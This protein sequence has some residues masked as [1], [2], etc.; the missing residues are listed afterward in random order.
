M[1]LTDDV[2]TGGE[3]TAGSGDWNSVT[4]TRTDAS[5]EAE[6]TLVIYTDIDAPADKKF[7]DKYDDKTLVGRHPSILTL[8]PPI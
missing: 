7:N 4:M 8:L 3:T 5:A 6:H 1:A 2:Y